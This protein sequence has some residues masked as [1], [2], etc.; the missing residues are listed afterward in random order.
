MNNMKEQGPVY[1]IP[2]NDRG[3][4]A[5]L[6][7]L[8]SAANAFCIWTAFN[9][10]QVNPE[11]GSYAKLAVAGLHVIEIITTG[12][13]LVRDL[14]AS[15]YPLPEGAVMATGW[16][17]RIA[18]RNFVFNVLPLFASAATLSALYALNSAPMPPLPAPGG[19]IQ[20]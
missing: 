4:R 8:I 1:D 16:R 3:R 2:D 9:I 10:A 20:V 13:Q 19:E 12:Y 11:I 7:G 18:K 6:S 17:E 5:L 15:D 14:R